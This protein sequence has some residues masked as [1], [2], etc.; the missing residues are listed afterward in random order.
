MYVII[1]YP[2]SIFS[3]WLAL[4]CGRETLFLLLLS[5][6]IAGKTKELERYLVRDK[7]RTSKSK[8]NKHICQRTA[9]N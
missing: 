2:L 6:L 8:S 7:S 9:D 3:G 4:Y 5:V 1:L